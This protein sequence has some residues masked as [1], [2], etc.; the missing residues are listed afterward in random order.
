MK[1]SNGIICPLLLIV[2]TKSQKL[3]D[4][5]LLMSLLLVITKNKCIY[6]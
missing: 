5:I 3:A 2:I 1:P 6:F 4:L